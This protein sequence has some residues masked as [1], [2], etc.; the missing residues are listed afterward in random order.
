MIF[1]SYLKT[2]SVRN[3]RMR[4]RFIIV[5]RSVKS[6]SVTVLVRGTM[7]RNVKRKSEQLNS[8]LRRPLRGESWRKIIVGMADVKDVMYILSVDLISRRSLNFVN[9]T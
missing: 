7:V 4:M 5:L 9:A 6:A 8:R 3:R 1:S 2:G